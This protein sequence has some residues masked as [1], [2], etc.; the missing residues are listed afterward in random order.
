MFVARDD[1]PSTRR[2]LVETIAVDQSP[3]DRCTS[4]PS[5][6][7][8][9]QH[10]RTSRAWDGKTASRLRKDAVEFPMKVFRS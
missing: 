1:C 8:A 7:R 6:A 9:S 2:M 10:W 4:V 5:R 3:R